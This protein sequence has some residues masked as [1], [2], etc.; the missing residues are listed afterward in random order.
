MRVAVVGHVEWVEF[1]RLERMPQAGEIVHAL[2]SW[3]EPAGGGSVAAVRLAELAGQS[4]FFTALGDDERGRRTVPAL[5]TLGVRVEAALRPEPQRRAVTFVEASG[6]RTITVIGPR[7]APRLDDPLPWN[8]LDGC[9]AV[10]FTGGDAGALAAARRARTLVATPR[11]IAT[12]AEARVELDALVGSGRDEGERYRRGDLEPEPRLVVRTEGATGGTY[13][14]ESGDRGRFP[15]QPLPG[16][17][18]DAYGCG[19]S[20][21]AGLTY[22]LGARLPLDEALALAARCGAAQLTRSGAYDQQLGLPG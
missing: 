3:A 2:D 13:E 1:V 17:V 16:P 12:L 22:G 14:L 9:D 7:I 18:A 10:Y 6:E 19:D 8:E 5:A 15:A 20:F 21:A 11:A 4:L